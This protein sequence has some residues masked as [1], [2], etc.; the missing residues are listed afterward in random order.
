MLW[1][2]YD[3]LKEKEERNEENKYF[4]FN[5]FFSLFLELVKMGNNLV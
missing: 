2:V 1:I 4:N 3:S 5:S